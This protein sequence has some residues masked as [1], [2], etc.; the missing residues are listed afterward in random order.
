MATK[1]WRPCCGA[2][3]AEM[4]ARPPDGPYKCSSCSVDWDG[5]ELTDSEVRVNNYLILTT[6]LYAVRE[7]NKDQ[8]SEEE[9]GIMDQMDIA[10][11]ALADRQEIDKVEKEIEKRWPR[12][13]P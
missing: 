4:P 9:D 1:E 11:Y 13:G 3:R 5:S 2:C 8:D 7:K 12:K 6:K 10:W